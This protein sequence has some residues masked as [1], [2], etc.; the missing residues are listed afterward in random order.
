MK[1]GLRKLI[2]NLLILFVAVIISLLLSEIVLRVVWKAPKG[3]DVSSI[4]TPDV[5]IG[6]RFIPGSHVKVSGVMND[7]ISDININSYGFRGKDEKI[8]MASNRK[9]ILLFGDS[10]IFGVGVTEADTIDA[11]MERLL[12]EAGTKYNV[13]NMGMPGLGTLAEEQLFYLYAPVFK[14]DA[15]IF[16]VSGAND[17][18]DNEMYIRER[19]NTED[20][21]SRKKN[22]LFLKD[23]LRNTYVY[24]LAKHSIRQLLIN[25]PTSRKALKIANLNFGESSLLIEQWYNEGWPYQGLLSMKA[26]FKR[27]NTFCKQEGIEIIIAII[28]S[29]IQ[30]NVKYKVLMEAITPDSIVEEFQKDK[31][32]PQRIIKEFCKENSIIYVELLDCF[33]NLSQ[34][35]NIVLKHANDGHFNARGTFEIARLLVEELQRLE[36][37]N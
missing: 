33:I 10:E 2:I 4:T 28:P 31:K 1:E 36:W 32:R 16:V 9:R 3:V 26:A 15:V 17:L 14:P 30:F 35:E 18:G 6:Y 7:Y 24:I 25:S 5:L 12:N 21:S 34:Q 20:I 8:D 27:I 19:H 11:C 29:R 13:V 23:A 22:R 37:K